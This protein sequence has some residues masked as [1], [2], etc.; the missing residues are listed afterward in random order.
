[1]RCDSMVPEIRARHVTLCGVGVL[2]LRR[3]SPPVLQIRTF[4][5]RRTKCGSATAAPKA[6]GRSCVADDVPR[7]EG[8][9]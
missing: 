8:G 5:G 7:V 1:M 3:Q 2:I 4:A 6:N 9:V